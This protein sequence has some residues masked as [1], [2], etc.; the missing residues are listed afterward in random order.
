M[1]SNL[2]SKMW[3]GE[4]EII[5]SDKLLEGQAAQGWKRKRVHWVDK[6]DERA[7]EIEKSVPG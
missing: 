2:R 4:M 7:F 6:E 5:W 3:Q 1:L